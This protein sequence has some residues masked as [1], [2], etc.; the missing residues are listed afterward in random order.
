MDTLES[1]NCQLC[2]SGRSEKLF[3][4]EDQQF[5][6]N[7][8]EF[9]V[10]R[11]AECGLRYVNPRPSAGE[12]ASYY[13]SVYFGEPPRRESSAK[14]LVKHV[15]RRIKRAILE[16]YYGYPCSGRSYPW[17]I[18]RKCLLFPE[19]IWRVV[20]GKDAIPYVGQGRLLDVGCGIGVNLKRFQEEGWNVYG[21]EAGPV[22][23]QYA[24]QM[25][26]D[27]RVYT[28]TI[29]STS[30][31]EASFDVVIFNHSLEHMLHPGE[32]LKQVARLLKPHGR[33]VVAVPNASGMEARLFGP[34][35]IGWDLPRHLFHFDKDTLTALLRNSG[36]EVERLR[37]GKGSA[38][39][40]MTADKCL[41]SPFLRALLTSKIIERLII[42]PLCI[43][44]GHLGYGTEI[45]VY[46][47]K[48]QVE[49]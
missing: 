5:V 27:D 33:L 22:A 38:F 7:G 32:A 18:V 40:V 39:F 12:I 45:R 43:I 2:G 10:V 29:E 41:A 14:R 8:K 30:L 21:V 48:D 24:K 1:T 3:A 28:G 36:F 47:K 19:W 26:G 44:A 25:V 20:R 11:C 13:P 37:S 42:R 6:K 15:S 46:A 35:W 49:A 9:A 16:D 4:G 31:P 34:R 23:A 17:R